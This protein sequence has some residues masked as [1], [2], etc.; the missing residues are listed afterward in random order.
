ML[1]K[2]AGLVPGV[3][4]PWPEALM[5]RIFGW[6]AA[7]VLA[8]AISLGAQAQGQTG[9]RGADRDND[10]KCDVCGRPA[11][12]IGQGR[13]A[14]GGQGFGRMGRGMRAR[15]CQCPACRNQNQSQP[16]AQA[17]QQKN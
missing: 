11:A 4:F 17:P 2:P 5:K 10:G 15:N 6:A 13:R 8:G 3:L 1:S 12:Q 7:A 14:G 16:P 9:P